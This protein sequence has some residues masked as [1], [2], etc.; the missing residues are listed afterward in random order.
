M[1][2]M[3]HPSK[4]NMEA[5]AL[6]RM[7]MGSVNHIEEGKK[8]LVKDVYHL[9]YLGVRLSGFD[10]SDILMQNR[11][12]SSLIVDVKAKKDLYQTLVELMKLVI[13]KKIEVFSQWA[14]GVHC[15]KGN[16][17]SLLLMA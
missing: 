12:K 7:S 5:N 3:H 16:Y 17:V 13:E 11:S 10:K 4:A 1:S 14:D 6:S 15:Y 9:A 2:V 8:E